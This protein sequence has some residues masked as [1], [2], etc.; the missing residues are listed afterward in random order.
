MHG[1]C[2]PFSPTPHR[3]PDGHDKSIANPPDT[4]DRVFDQHA[5]T[6]MPA[7]QPGGTPV[8]AFALARAC[9]LGR[10]VESLGENRRWAGILG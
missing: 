10:E 6:G 1:S 2:G 3:P 8:I 5:I 7:R 4:L 9:S